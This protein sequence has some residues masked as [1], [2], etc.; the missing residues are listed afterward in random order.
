MNVRFPVRWLALLALSGCLFSTSS[1]PPLE[2]AEYVTPDSP[3]AALANLALAF[4]RKDLE[5]LDGL[6]ASDY[7]FHYDPYP[8]GDC[9]A[10]VWTREEDLAL[11]ASLFSDGTLKRLYL[12]FATATGAEPA[13]ALGQ[14]GWMRIR[15]DLPWME[16]EYS[17]RGTF[18]SHGDIEEFFF[19]P[20]DPD[21]GENPEHWYLVE[22]RDFAGFSAPDATAEDFTPVLPIRWWVLKCGY[23]GS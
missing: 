4:A 16:V 9:T 1:G 6:L 11:T 5:T 13:T 7:A 15:P 3:A 20:G 23:Q 12:R 19:R 10:G 22:W 8:E 17:D 21:Q 18:V 2:D 14:E